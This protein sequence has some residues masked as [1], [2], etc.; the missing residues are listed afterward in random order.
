MTFCD[1]YLPGDVSTDF[2]FGRNHSTFFEVKTTGKFNVKIC[3][4]TFIISWLFPPYN[5]HNY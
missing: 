2:N 4:S 3:K 5:Q 1:I